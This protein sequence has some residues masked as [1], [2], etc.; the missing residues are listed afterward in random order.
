MSDTEKAA[1]LVP[2]MKD[3]GAVKA[4]AEAIG[5]TAEEFADKFSSYA[6]TFFELVTD[7]ECYPIKDYD[8]VVLQ[9]ST[10]LKVQDI[11]QRSPEDAFFIGAAL[12]WVFSG[13]LK[14]PFKPEQTQEE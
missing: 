6:N 3:V 11:K 9:L 12:G 8:R 5:V 4:G 7:G 2:P 14:M 13:Y 10:A 1:E